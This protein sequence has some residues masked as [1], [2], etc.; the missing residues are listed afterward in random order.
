MCCCAIQDGADGL[1][2][3]SDFRFMSPQPLPLSVPPHFQCTKALDSVCLSEGVSIHAEPQPRDCDGAPSDA[4]FSLVP[5]Q[6]PAWTLC[7]PGPGDMEG[8]VEA[9]ERA[10]RAGRAFVPI[11]P[12]FYTLKLSTNGLAVAID[13]YT[14][15]R[16][17]KGKFYNVCM[18]WHIVT[19]PITITMTIFTTTL[20][21]TVTPICS[22]PH[23]P[24]HPRLRSSPPGVPH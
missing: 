13:G 5:V 16:E 12:V 19:M 3:T 23:H 20:T 8:W 14:T 7:V 15:R 22:H 9:L 21:L 6:A 11:N 1:D 2:Q 17:P 24:H 4:V 10:G 18:T